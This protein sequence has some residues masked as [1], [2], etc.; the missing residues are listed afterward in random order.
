MNAQVP[1]GVA[2]WHRPTPPHE[3]PWSE[4][5]CAD[6]VNV[7]YVARPLA[8]DRALVEVVEA[9][10]VALLVDDFWNSRVP[11]GEFWRRIYEADYPDVGDVNL[12]PWASDR[13]RAALAR[14]APSAPVAPGA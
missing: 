6:H 8:Q 11:T 5:K 3:R 2:L 13:L 9:A 7:E 14:L 12:R 10:A 4:H 1:A